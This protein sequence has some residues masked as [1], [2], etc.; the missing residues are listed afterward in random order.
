LVPALACLAL[1]GCFLQP[2]KFDSALNLRKDGSFTIAYKGQIYLLALSKIA[3]MAAKAE[4]ES[5]F[6]ADTCHDDNLDERD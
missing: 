3:D 5:E 4:R 2:G 1:T 6:V